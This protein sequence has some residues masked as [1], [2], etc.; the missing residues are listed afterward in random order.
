MKLILMM[1]MCAVTSASTIFDFD[2]QSN[3]RDWV[4]VDD[5]V[6]GGK[7]SGSF[8]IN[9]EGHGVFAGAISLANN[10]GFSSVRYRMN[11]KSVKEFKSIILKI[12]GDAKRYQF[13]IKSNSSDYYSYV[14]TFTTNG[15]WQEIEIPLESMIPTFRGR[16]LDKPNFSGESIEQIAFLIG[17]KKQENFRLLIDKITLK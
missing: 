14:A 13:R 15:Q 10:G 17:N 4:I 16:K 1:A 11:K 6:M 12:K 2:K 8:K 3:I 7:S 9:H 5:I